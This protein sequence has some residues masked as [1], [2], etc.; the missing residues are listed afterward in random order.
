MESV[1]RE[2]RRPSSDVLSGDSADVYFR[3]AEEILEGEGMDPVV[4]MEVFSR[5]EGILCG[6]DEA[7]VLLA[8]VLVESGEEHVVESLADGDTFSPKE[9]VMRIRAR[10]RAFGLYETAIL[11]MLAQSTGWANAARECVTAAS[12]QPVISSV[13]VTS[14][15][16]SPT[17]STTRPSWAA[18]S[19][20]RRRLV[21]A[22]PAWRRRAPC[23]TRWSW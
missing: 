5:A 18:A 10:Y 15:R 13:P 12:P 1:T 7:K 9:I 4:V 21:R 8:S 11:G 3:R 20:P 17:R 16:T 19:A 2:R 23:R 14:I 22:W 6:I